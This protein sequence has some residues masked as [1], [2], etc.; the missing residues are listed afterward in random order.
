MLLITISDQ[1]PNCYK[2]VEVYN[3]YFDSLDIM[4]LFSYPSSIVITRDYCRFTTN[5]AHEEGTL[6]ICDFLTS[7]RDFNFSVESLWILVFNRVKKCYNIVVPR[8]FN[9]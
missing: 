5:A 9:I 7:E 4:I 2:A 8:D 6:M 1:Y 3:G